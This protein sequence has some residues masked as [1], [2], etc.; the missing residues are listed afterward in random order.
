MKS[1]IEIAVKTAV[2]NCFNQEIVVEIS[3]PKKEFGDYTTNVCY[4]IG[5]EITRTPEIADN[6]V[7]E[8]MQKI[9]AE[10]VNEISIAGAGFINITLSDAVILQ[11]LDQKAE[12]I[13]KDQVIVTEIFRP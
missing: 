8:R 4:A 13:Y 6:L 5:R 10:K 7:D 1:E 3:R 9:L 2:K 11:S 12:Q